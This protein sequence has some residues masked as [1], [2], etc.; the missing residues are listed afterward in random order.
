MLEHNKPLTTV[1]LGGNSGADARDYVGMDCGTCT[2]ALSARLDGEAGPAPAAE[3]D[4][5]LGICPKCQAW[6]A[7]ATLLTRRVRVRA[8]TPTPDLVGAVLAE[9]VR[10]SRSSAGA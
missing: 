6:Y 10:P 4:E 8:V 2:E 7:D 9:A 5:H 1:D 3:V